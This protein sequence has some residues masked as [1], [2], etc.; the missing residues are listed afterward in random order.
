MELC[1]CSTGKMHILFSVLLIWLTFICNYSFSMESQTPEMVIQSGHAWDVSALAFSKDSGILV[2]GGDDGTIIIWSVATGEIIRSLKTNHEEISSI[3]FSPDGKIF[4]SASYD[5]IINLWS[6]SGVGPFVTLGGENSVT[7]LSFSPDGTMLASADDNGDISLWSMK[8]HDLTGIIYAHSTW[9]T[10]VD[11]HP[12]GRVLVS[13]GGMPPEYT[14]ELLSVESC[15]PVRTIE[16]GVDDIGSVAFS[17]DGSGILV[18]YGE[19]P[20]KLISVDSGRVIHEYVRDLNCQINVIFSPDG[21]S[22]LFSGCYDN[23][24]ELISVE[25]GEV[26]NTIETYYDG[27][28]ESTAFSPDS[29]LFASGGSDGAIKIWSYPTGSLV[30]TLEPLGWQRVGHVFFEPSGDKL[31]AVLCKALNMKECAES[32]LVGFLLPGG[33]IHHITDGPPFGQSG[34]DA[35]S[36]D[37]KTLSFLTQGS[38]GRHFWSI[39]DGREIGPVDPDGY[40]RWDLMNPAFNPDGKTA[41]TFICEEVRDAWEEY[42]PCTIKLFSINDGKFI[43]SNIENINA[44]GASDM[45]FSP[46][47][48][49]LAVGF[50]GK[51]DLYSIQSGQIANSLEGISGSV[52]TMAY[53]WDGNKI[54]AVLEDGEIIVW[55]LP[56]GR[57]AFS[58][59]ADLDNYDSISISRDNRFIATSGDEI[60]VQL[61]DMKTG[62]NVVDMIPVDSSCWIFVTPKGHFDFS[63]SE[64][65]WERIRWRIRDT[66][67]PAERFF[68]EFYKP[69]LLSSVLSVIY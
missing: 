24:L 14:V 46:D 37:G 39:A 8:N 66:L 26:I 32:Q 47:G 63:D 42:E 3:V 49:M 59:Q 54:A 60:K 31:T 45:I 69:G 27:F 35:I 9:A 21:K 34:V 4:A 5:G 50:N 15:E 53:N 56:D 51:I 30:R 23:A 43:T 33:K 11:F 7:S 62:K 44:T 10:S 19:A 36:Q 67:Y 55:N 28:V 18:F 6:L 22:L 13:S 40:G 52:V 61:W 64:C 20:S 41:A 16:S 25:S 38:Y 48:K 17:P 68:N 2:S 1:K 57:P 29:K 65:A 58:F 12:D